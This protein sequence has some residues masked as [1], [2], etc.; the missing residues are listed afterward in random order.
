MF[1][2]YNVSSKKHIQ[3]GRRKTKPFRTYLHMNAFLY[4]CIR[5]HN[6]KSWNHYF[7]RPVFFVIFYQLLERSK[8]LYFKMMTKDMMYSK[9]MLSTNWHLIVTRSAHLLQKLHFFLVSERKCTFLGGQ[10]SIQINCIIVR[11]YYLSNHDFSLTW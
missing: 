11:T 6:P 4:F 5:N 1:L 2:R 10:S 9:K 8:V 7:G 3:A